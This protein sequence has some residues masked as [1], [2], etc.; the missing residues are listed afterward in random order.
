MIFEPTGIASRLEE[1]IAQY[2]GSFT[3]P[4]HSTLGYRVVVDGADRAD[5]GPVWALYDRGQSTLFAESQALESL[6]D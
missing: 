2:G 5:F 3:N 4:E 1:V 6:H